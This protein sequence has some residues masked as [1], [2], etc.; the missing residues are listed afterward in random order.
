MNANFPGEFVWLSTLKNISQWTT[1]LFLSPC[2]VHNFWS[3]LRRNSCDHLMINHLLACKEPLWFAPIHGVFHLQKLS[4]QKYFFLTKSLVP[5][6]AFFFSFLSFLLVTSTLLSWCCRLQGRWDTNPEC[7][8]DLRALICK[9]A[10]MP[11]LSLSFQNLGTW[12]PEK[13]FAHPSLSPHFQGDLWFAELDYLIVAV[14]NQLWNTFN[15]LH[16]LN[17]A[18]LAHR[19]L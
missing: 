2:N 3:L 18:K 7:Y 5:L 6:V 13:G 15:Y 19:F 14:Q 4:A 17:S 9:Q 8:V 1:I 16:L 12:L 11:L 10:T